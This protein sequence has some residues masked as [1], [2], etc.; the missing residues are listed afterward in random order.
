MIIGVFL[1][2]RLTCFVFGHFTKLW[3]KLKKFKEI[4][5]LRD[6]I[7]LTEKIR[8][9]LHLFSPKYSSVTSIIL[10]FENLAHLINARAH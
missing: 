2:I 5:Q 8:L 4:T 7:E 10:W 3:R 1:T 6:F 9:K